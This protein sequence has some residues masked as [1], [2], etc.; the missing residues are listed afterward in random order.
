M[1]QETSGRVLVTG[2]SG[3]IGEAL[4][5]RFARAGYD[6]VLVA[7]RA[8]KLKALADELGA[9]HQVSVVT[10]AAD[11]AQEGAAAKLA[12]TL[13]RRKL[14]ID[15]LVNNAG[16]IAQGPFEQLDPAN[17]QALIR[18][19]IAATTDLMAHF[20]PPMVARGKGRV[21]NIASTS[22]FIPVPFVAVYAASKSY[23]LSL[24][25]S[26]SEELRGTGVTITA[27]CPGVTATPMMDR[28]SADNA[29][30]IKLIGSTVLDVEEVADAGFDACISGQVVRIPGKFNLATALSGR[31]MPK[32]LT[33]R[34]FGLMGR[35]AH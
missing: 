2:A 19:N 25:E 35:M 1:N 32:W 28:M 30:L 12:A 22:A 6:L 27:L 29:G 26:V 9:K 34:A 13:K 21:L 20:I 4:A 33:R 16:I 18:L 10:I 14:T 8:D 23:L 3:G 17:H 7:R 24:S 11:L 15:I 5:R 31:M